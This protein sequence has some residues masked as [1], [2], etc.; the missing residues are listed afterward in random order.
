MSSFGKTFERSSPYLALTLFGFA[1]FYVLFQSRWSVQNNSRKILSEIASTPEETVSRFMQ[2]V[3]Q[4][5]D[6]VKEQFPGVYPLLDVGDE[7][8]LRSLMT[9][10]LHQTDRIT[11][12]R[13]AS[14]SLEFLL[15]E[16]ENLLITRTIKG[17]S[18]N[19]HLTLNFKPTNKVISHQDSADY[20]PREQSWYQ[21]ALSRPV[22]APLFMS[23]PH[24]LFWT[25]VPGITVSRV[26]PGR[27]S[28]FA[29][30]AYD[31]PLS[32]ISDFTSHLKVSEN[33]Q[34]FILG[35]N[36][37][38]MGLPHMARDLAS[39][40]LN[41]LLLKKPEDAGLPLFGACYDR[42][43]ENEQDSALFEITFEGTRWWC[44]MRSMKLNDENA[45]TF[46]VLVPE[47]DMLGIIQKGQR[48]IIITFV[49]GY[50]MLIWIFWLYRRTRNMNRRIRKQKNV[51]ETKNDE[52]M[53]SINYAHRIQSAILDAE[54][55]L[56]KHFPNSFLWSRPR[57]VVGGDFLWYENVEFKARGFQQRIHFLAMVDCT[58][59]GIPAAFITL[60]C[61]AAL[62]E[63][64]EKE[65]CPSPPDC[66]S[67]CIAHW[68]S[69]WENQG[70]FAMDLTFH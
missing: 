34:F 26:I 21:G 6:L 16:T 37:Q 23:E 62:N 57:D 19:N 8:Q 10:V 56:K 64:I 65:T 40:T 25:G 30:L 54:L 70:N 35:K 33:G 51:I 17:N 47:K 42:F 32:A 45:I 60:F 5:F 41:R 53:L 3:W 52:L 68:K 43:S 31:I 55:R 28:N 49:I 13:I 2:P 20:D 44:R 14:D 48:N 7:Q 9:P 29:V 69:L 50:L 63:A 39:D 1:L 15:T 46:G 61:Q 12:I 18:P 67:A 4:S 58:G 27:A 22:S 11:C 66:L 24:Q 38:F 59:H 36:G